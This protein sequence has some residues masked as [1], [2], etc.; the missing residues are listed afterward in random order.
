ML[1]WNFLLIDK[2]LDC[3]LSGRNC[4]LQHDSQASSSSSYGVKSRLHCEQSC[5]PLSR[6]ITRTV[7][8]SLTAEANG[9]L[10]EYAWYKCSFGTLRLLVSKCTVRSHSHRYSQHLDSTKVTNKTDCGNITQ[11]RID[12]NSQCK[13]EN[14]WRNY[15]D[16]DV[17]R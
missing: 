9:K 10:W 4:D 2:T 12:W 1:W 11:E 7:S 6:N 16:F 14:R 8:Y 15:I 13:K 5:M 3:W 17:F